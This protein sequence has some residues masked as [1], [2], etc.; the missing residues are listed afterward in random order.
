MEDQPR[1]PMIIVLNGWK[2]ILMVRSLKWQYPHLITRR[3][4]YKRK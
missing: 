3:P 4:K 1:K 2:C